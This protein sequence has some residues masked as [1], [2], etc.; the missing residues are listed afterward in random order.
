MT[1]V[2]R[3]CGEALAPTAGG[4]PRSWCS[5][6]CAKLHRPRVGRVYG[7]TTR[8]C[9]VCGSSYRYSHAAQRTC[10]RTCGVQLRRAESMQRTCLTC[11]QAFA[12]TSAGKAADYCST[13]CQPSRR[14]P[15]PARPAW[16]VRCAACCQEF[17]TRHVRRYCSP[18]CAAAGKKLTDRR[19]QQSRPRVGRRCQSC[20]TQI[21][22][23]N[24]CDA[25]RPNRSQRRRADKRRRR[26]LK[27]GVATERYTL[28]D[29]AVRDRRT[30]QLCRK[31][32]AMTRS[33]PHPKAPTI[34]HVVPLAEGGSDLRSNVQLAHFLCNSRK[35]NRGIQQ[36]TL[37]G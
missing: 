18:P 34:D 3:G 7:S 25:C 29:I 26:A 17:E 20:A 15:R 21:A 13:R 10:G 14:R 2:C 23:G 31:R 30:C 27:L 22:Q 37:I 16:S 19:Y 8:A 6:R 11:G 33:V 36:L 24:K 32:V 4:R 1:A 9:E 35:S 28:A 5:E 12:S